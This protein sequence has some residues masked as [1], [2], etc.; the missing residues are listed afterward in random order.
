MAHQLN[1]AD[2]KIM[3]LFVDGRSEGK[4]FGRWTPGLLSEQL[5]YSRQYIQSRLQLLTASGL[6]K[7][8]GGG[9]REITEDGLEKADELDF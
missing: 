5:D 1:E 4:P 3:E 7:V 6:L 9:V 2:E 8:I